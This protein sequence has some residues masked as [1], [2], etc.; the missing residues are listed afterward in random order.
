MI[1]NSFL[2]R[3][4]FVV[5]SF[6]SGCAAIDKLTAP[7]LGGTPANSALIVVKVEASMHGVLGITTSQEVIGGV[8]LRTDGSRRFDGQAVAGLI[9]FSDVPPGEY[10]LAR[11]DTNWRAG[12]M[13]YTHRYNV[14]PHGVSNFI[15]SVKVSEP[16]FLG[17]VTVEEVR[18]TDDR[19][20]RF[21][22][23]P[24]KTAERDTWETFMQLYQ[25]SPWT[26]AVQKRQSEL[27]N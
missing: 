11:V 9:I 5:A 15:V 16:Q 27:G 14:P 6:L 23:K 7:K 22:L 13:M 18:R 17:L 3:L 20:V 25:G 2:T 21:A 12:N 1:A 19:G 24:S 4:V 8:L 26:G 10:N